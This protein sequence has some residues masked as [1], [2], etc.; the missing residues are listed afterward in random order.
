M[1]DSQLVILPQP[2][3]FLILSRF[4]QSCYTDY[5]A[6]LRFLRKSCSPISLHIYCK[7]GYIKTSKAVS[8]SLGEAD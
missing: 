6:C 5:V 3:A 2:Q 4:L 7:Q 8:K 1:F